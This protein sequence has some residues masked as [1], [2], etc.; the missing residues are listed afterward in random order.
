MMSDPS[1]SDIGL[2]PRTTPRGGTA[3]CA[4]G[5]NTIGD[6]QQLLPKR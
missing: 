4:S 2:N 3:V 6:R 1:F 5:Y